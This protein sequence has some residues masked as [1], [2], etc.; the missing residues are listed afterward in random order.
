MKNIKNRQWFY[1]LMV[2]CIALSP[3]FITSCSDDDD[4]ASPA[5]GNDD[6]NEEQ[7]SSGEYG[8]TVTGDEETMLGDEGQAFFVD[9]MDSLDDGPSGFDPEEDAFLSLNLVEGGH[10]TS[11]AG[12][13]I[14]IIEKGSDRV[15]EGTYDIKPFMEVQFGLEGAIFQLNL[16]QEQSY[17]SMTEAGSIVITN[18]EDNVIE[19]YF[20]D[21]EL[22]DF[23][24]QNKSVNISGGFN[25][26][27]M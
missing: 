14:L 12:A 13:N 8:L 10:D 11:M 3:V 7:Y 9:E 21:V 2:C 15:G 19:G 20:E 25:A 4:D 26:I 6:D 18:R 1:G 17:T 24:D 27:K 23:M 16:S 22:Q 5:G